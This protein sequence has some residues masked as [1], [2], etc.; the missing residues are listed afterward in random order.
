MPFPSFASAR[1]L[2]K[3]HPYL[4]VQNNRKIKDPSGSR[5]LLTMKSSK[6][7]IFVPAP[8]GV[9]FCNRLNPRIHGSDNTM[10]TTA[11]MSEDFFTDTFVRSELNPII[12][13]KMAM[14]VESA[15]NAINKKNNAP[16]NCPKNMWLKIFGNVTKM[17]FGPCDGSTPNAKH[18]GKIMNPAMI[19][20]SVSS[21]STCSASPVSARFL[22]I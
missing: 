7:I 11:L 6:S 16:H 1:K 10:I 22:S 3:P 18:A 8:N 5:L 21:P 12:F 20:T 17:S 15:A 9:M 13:W 14:T 19:A 2:P 4:L